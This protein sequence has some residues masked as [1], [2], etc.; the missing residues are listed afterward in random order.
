VAHVSNGQTEADRLAAVERR[1]AE[2]EAIVRRY[3][4]IAAR[5]LTGPGARK[6]ARLLGVEVPR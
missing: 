4:A 5:F 1:L 3:E 6:L 2:L